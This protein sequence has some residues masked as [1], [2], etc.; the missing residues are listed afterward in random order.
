[1]QFRAQVR[2]PEHPPVQLKT[3]SKAAEQTVSV[4]WPVMVRAKLNHYG[5]IWYMINEVQCYLML[6]PR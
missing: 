5:G 2:E 4:L 1:M 3:E 6:L